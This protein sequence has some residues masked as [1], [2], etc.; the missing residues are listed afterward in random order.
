MCQFAIGPKTGAL[1]NFLFNPI[2]V[3]LM[4]ISEKTRLLIWTQQHG[5]VFSEKVEGLG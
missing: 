2:P 3:P 1:I 5:V 4:Q